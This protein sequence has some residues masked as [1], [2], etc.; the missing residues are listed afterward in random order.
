MADIGQ[1]YTD[2]ILEELERN[3]AQEYRQATKEIQAKLNAYMQQFSAEEKIMRDRLNAG[4]ITKKDFFDWRYR[5]IMNKRQWENMRDTLA[6]DYHN[7]NAIAYNMIRKRL[8]EVYALNANYAAYQL[9]HDFKIDTSFTLY[10]AD[11]VE[12]LMTQDPDFLPP[13]RPGG[14]TA[15]KLAENKDLIWNRQH[16][17]SAIMQGIIQGD[18][19]KELAKRLMQV[20][21]MNYHAA[22]RN[23][24][25]MMTGAQN[26]GRN[27]SY[28][29][30]ESK[31]TKLS[32]VW[33]SVLDG[34]VRHQHRMLHGEVRDGAK[35]SNGLRYPGDPDG[36]AGEVY[37][38]RC[39]MR[40]FLPGQ[41]DI[42]ISSPKMG[43]MSFEE[44]QQAKAPKKV[45]E[46][47][48]EFTQGRKSF[49]S[50]YD[51]IEKRNVQEFENAIAQ[52]YDD[53]PL[54]NGYD[55]D[56]GDY[57]YINRFLTDGQIE[58]TLS[59]DAAAQHWVNHE[60]K[61]NVIG[62][63]PG[64][65]PYTYAEAVEQRA[66]AIKENKEILDLTGASARGTAIHEYG[67]ALSDYISN[68]MVY[69]D[70]TALD[71]WE[72]YR[73]LSKDEIRK[74]LSIYAA[75]NRAEFEAECFA[76]LM[77]P[78]PR[79]LAVKYKSFLAKCM[80]KNYNIDT[81]KGSPVVT[82]LSQK[83]RRRNVSDM[84][85]FFLEKKEYKAIMSEL[86]T[87]VKDEN[88]PI[89]TLRFFSMFNEA[90]GVNYVYGY[91]RTGK[92]Q[93]RIVSRRET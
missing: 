70:K 44:W 49:R 13:P 29:R 76:E 26:A 30:I 47:T 35:F 38:C 72:W 16:I 1:R 32:R 28:D 63:R 84:P 6:A 87:W 67:H 58:N 8:P 74:G 51:E 78:N 7:A 3:I 42:P 37:N 34:R 46:Q 92:A 93:F 57:D 61:R 73:S 89:G 48:R 5:K 64:S 4:E 69:D 10:N 11:A 80:E 18:T 81:G 14:K 85:T 45:A 40:C 71:Y 65:T 52:L 83:A 43:D 27:D 36:A 25:T 79:P 62:Y 41:E 59:G 75:T 9:E 55:L 20:S 31:G 68:A 77:F 19:Q 54:P 12:R 53:Y 56:I 21:D 82:K 50:D 15:R 2:D 91:E 22:V 60:A 17:Q 66:K 39:S 24:R 86:A 33:I 90:D 88:C 23:A